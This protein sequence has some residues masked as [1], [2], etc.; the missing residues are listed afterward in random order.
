LLLG[1]LLNLLL[2]SCAGL[3]MERPEPAVGSSIHDPKEQGRK[4]LEAIR[5]LL[6]EQRQRQ[7]AGVE[8]RSEGNREQ[9]S[10]SWPPDW[11]ASFFS[12]TP[13]DMSAL[14]RGALY[15]PAT[16]PMPRGSRMSSADVTAKTPW[17]PPSARGSEVE[18]GR[19]VPA[20]TIPAPGGS[21]YP[22]RIRCVPDLL[23]GQRCH[24]E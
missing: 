11:L 2:L 3:V 20:Y 7:A 14:D 5:A 10:S 4:N 12:Q 17:V 23:G 21:G 24:T 15:A 9:E 19:M 16:S 18:P 1:C 6:A 22:D 13:T 8:S